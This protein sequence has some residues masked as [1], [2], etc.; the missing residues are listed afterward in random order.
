MTSRKN[1]QLGRLVGAMSLA[2]GL[3]AFTP[4]ANANVYATN[5]KINGGPNIGVVAYGGSAGISYLLNEPA[6]LGL[7]L[8]IK[9]GTNLVRSMLIVTGPGTLRGTNNIVWDGKDNNGDYVPGG[10]Y[11]VSLTAAS[12]GY[13]NW[14][15]ITDDKNELNY[16]AA[17][18]GIA[19]DQNGASPFYGRVFVANSANGTGAKPGDLTGI[20]KLNADG[21]AAEEGAVATGGYPWVGDGYSPWRVKVSADDNVYISD[22]SGRGEVL[23]WDAQ[24]TTNSLLPVLMNTNGNWAGTV[25]L[26]G[27]FVTGSGTNSQLWMADNVP[28][29]LGILRWQLA[30]N[31]ACVPNDKGMT[32]VGT[33]PHPYNLSDSPV[34]VALDAAGNIY[35]IQSI[36]PGDPTPRV[37]R[38]PAPNGA[39]TVPETNA[40]WAVGGGDDSYAEASGIAVDPTGTYLAVSFEGLFSG[41]GNTKILYATNGALAANLDGGSV[42]HD[43]TACA[44]DAVGNV[45]CTEGSAGAQVWRAFSPPGTNQA[46]TV[47]AVSIIVVSSPNLPPTFVAPPAN[48]NFTIN[49]GSVLTVTNVATDPD[50]IPETLTYILVS[51]PT[52]ATLDAGTGV[53]T[54]RPLP[55]QADSTNLIIIAVNDNGAPNLSATNTFSVTVGTSVPPTIS[56]PAWAGGQFR[57][58]INGRTG[59]NYAVLASTNLVDWQTVFSTNSPALPFQWIDPNTASYPRRFYR[60][61]ASSPAP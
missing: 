20:L 48:T 36:F 42:N 21:S 12:S 29:G 10:T 52:N 4:P 31:G 40:V 56:A 43:D 37:F 16:V 41:K 18:R 46:T 58:L 25:N 27:P 24:L 3:V 15:Q 13:T 23:R 19:V 44:W 61:A 38:F 17:A 59:L 34:D 6:S 39:Q 32:I 26:N 35:T 51:G 30:L 7:T 33:G 50:V 11:A 8:G 22:F 54:W 1:P 5:L 2:L 49:V 60:V 14:T 28:S 53:F 9:A 47:A 55:A 45:Y 57:L